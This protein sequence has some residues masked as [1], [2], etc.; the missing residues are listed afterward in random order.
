[1]PVAHNPPPGENAYSERFVQF[2]ELVFGTELQTEDAHYELRQ[3]QVVVNSQWENAYSDSNCIK[4]MTTLDSVG[5]ER[6]SS[7]TKSGSVWGGSANVDLGLNP[8]LAFTASV[9]KTNEKAVAS[10]KIRRCN[11]IKTQYRDGKIQWDFDI[12][13]VSS[14]KKGLVL[15]KDE[16]PTVRFMFIGESSENKPVPP[17]KN[18][19]IA[20]TSCWTMISPS[21]PSL[22]NP[23]IRKILDSFR[24]TGDTQTI[25]SYSNLLQIVTLNII[26]LSKFSKPAFYKAK[27]EFKPKTDVPHDVIEKLKAPK[28]VC[29]T[30]KVVRA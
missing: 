19:D 18:M 23:W 11:A 30:P 9:R 7:S 10:E 6:Q 22:K 3:L 20:I 1:M 17:P 25:L 16:L 8:N 26:D 5:G 21:G 13:D 15:P 29:V 12:N 4:P 27:V 14:Q 2:T 24:Q 28:T